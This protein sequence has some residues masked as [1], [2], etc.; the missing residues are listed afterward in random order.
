MDPLT[1]GLLFGGA[2]LLQGL[3]TAIGSAEAAGDF[4]EANRL[5][6]KAQEEIAALNPQQ[7]KAIKAEV[8]DSAFASIAE[9]PEGREAQLRALQKL[10]AMSSGEDPESVAAYARAQSEAAQT[11]RGLRMAALQRLAQRGAG[12]TSGLAL[13]AQQ[14]AAQAATQQANM[15]GLETA[16]EARRRALAALAA[17]GQL[18]GQLRQQDYQRLAD[19]A[20]AQDTINRFNAGQR[21]DLGRL[22]WSA[23][24]QKAGL[25][26]G[27]YEQA[28]REREA[29][30]ARTAATY[31]S[32]GQAI[33]QTVMAGTMAYQYG[34]KK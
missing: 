22:A 9:P 33:P 15:R 1:I 31:S 30:G 18:G 7:L 20:A 4:E 27:Q 28:A 17:S 12:A 34:Q 26:G 24:A 25:M 16:A 8:G 5:R 13:A 14:D 32:I 6:A 11:E 2:T 10:E 21:L 3:I 29:E 23:E 19:K